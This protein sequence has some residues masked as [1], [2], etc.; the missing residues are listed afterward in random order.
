LEISFREFRVPSDA[1]QQFVY[2]DHAM[3]PVLA[4]KPLVGFKV[5][6]Q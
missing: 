1:V 2:R 5:V 6:L 3:S 4:Q